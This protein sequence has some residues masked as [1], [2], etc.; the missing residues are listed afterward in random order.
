MVGAVLLSD[1]FAFAG[2]KPREKTVGI[3]WLTVPATTDYDR[4][5][6]VVI[7]LSQS[8]EADK[9]LVVKK[10]KQTEYVCDRKP[11]RFCGGAFLWPERFPAGQKG[12]D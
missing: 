9:G 10:P 12:G 5:A 8:R 6:F 4:D 3:S 11:S 1:E 7:L 2:V